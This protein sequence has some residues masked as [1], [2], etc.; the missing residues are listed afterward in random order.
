[1]SDTEIQRLGGQVNGALY[2]EHPQAPQ[3]SLVVAQPVG[4][5]VHN[6]LARSAQIHMRSA[7]WWE[8][9]REVVEGPKGRI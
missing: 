6:G 8:D 2:I 5:S 3:A 7:H 4:E 1:M 9:T